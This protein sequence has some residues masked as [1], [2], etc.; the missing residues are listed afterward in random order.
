VLKEIH[1]KL[2]ALKEYRM[3]VDSDECVAQE[4]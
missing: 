1:K 4:I 3:D 2:K